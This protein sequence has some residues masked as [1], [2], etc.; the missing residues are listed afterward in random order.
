MTWNGL[1]LENIITRSKINISTFPKNKNDWKS[2]ATN[3]ITVCKAF[4]NQ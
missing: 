2:L 3:L 4:V 1:H